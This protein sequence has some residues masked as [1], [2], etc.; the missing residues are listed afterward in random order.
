MSQDITIKRLSGEPLKQYIPDL[1]RLRIQVF[2]DFP[3]LYDGTTDYEE[4]YLQTYIRT[5]ESVIVLAMDGDVIIGASTGIPMRHESAEFIQPFIDQGYDVNKIFYCAESVLDKRYRGLG[6]GVRFFDEREAH[7]RE[8]GG[9][10]YTS[11]CCVD[12]PVD[13]PLRPESYVPLDRFWTKR[14]YVKHPELVTRYKWK[15]IDQEEE[16]W[17]SMTFWLKPCED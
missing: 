2:R 10:D 1:A 16:S 15:D 9:F 17:K 3:Y 7:A 6:L 8:L 14:G 5:N 13:H 12:R 11:F 4:Q